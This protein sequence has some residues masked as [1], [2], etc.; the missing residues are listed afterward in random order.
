MASPPSLERRAALSALSAVVLTVALSTVQVA[1]LGD[2]TSV[3]TFGV[4]K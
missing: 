4:V 1:P 3:I 2:P